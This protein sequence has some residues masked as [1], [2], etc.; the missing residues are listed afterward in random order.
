MLCLG[1][2]R[3]PAA[4]II[5]GTLQAWMEA[6]TDSRLWDQDRDTAR[7]RQ[8]FLTMAKTRRTWPAPADFIESLPPIRQEMLPP[9]VKPS[10]P[11]KVEAIMRELGKTL[12]VR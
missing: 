1:L 9:P 2:D 4:E 11:A 8:A 7:V 12:G 5:P 10:D 3:T 6:V